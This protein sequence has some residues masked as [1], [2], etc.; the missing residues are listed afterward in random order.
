MLRWQPAKS[1]Q[2]RLFWKG[3]GKLQRSTTECR[4]QCMSRRVIAAT[5]LPRALEHVASLHGDISHSPKQNGASS[6]IATHFR[7]LH[8]T[9]QT[10]VHKCV[11]GRSSILRWHP[12]KND[13]SCLFLHMHFLSTQTEKARKGIS[14][15]NQLTTVGDMVLSQVMAAARRLRAME[16]VTSLH[17]NIPQSPQTEAPSLQESLRVD[18]NKGLYEL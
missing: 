9:A 7:H 2:S 16:Y 3:K 4:R 14:N 18:V 15:P 8:M 11:Q 6:Y 17:R 1:A 12:A 5:H 13:H 10:A